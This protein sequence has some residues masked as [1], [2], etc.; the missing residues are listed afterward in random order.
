[1]KQPYNIK[2]NFPWQGMSEGEDYMWNIMSEKA[3]TS[4]YSKVPL[5]FRALNLRCNALNRVPIYIY[6]ARTEVEEYPFEE[7]FPLKDLLWLAEASVL[8][9]GS[10]YL[11]K[12]QNKYNIEKGLQWLNPTTMNVKLNEQNEKVFWQELNGRRYPDNGFWT[13]DELLYWAMFN[14]LNDLGGGV[15]ALSLASPNGD[16]QHY[17]TTFLNKFFKSGAMPVTMVMLPSGTQEPERERVENWFKK[18]VQGLKNAFRVLGVRGELK[19]EKMTPELKSFELEK[20]D[21]HSIDNIAWAFDIPKTLLT[22]DSSNKA[23]ADTEYRNF[24][25]NTIEPR[26]QWFETRINKWLSEYNYRI[27][28]APQEMAEMKEDENKKATAFKAYVDAGMSLQLAAAVTGVDIPE[29]FESFWDEETNKPQ[30]TVL[31]PGQQANDETQQEDEQQQDMQKWYRKS[32][33][34][35]RSGKNAQCEFVSAFIPEDRRLKVFESL[36]EI[37]NDVELKKLFDA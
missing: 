37:K 5:I 19:V 3:H 32:L 6:R 36:S 22:S 29:D 12:L 21:T 17:V 16:L 11:L 1:M 23:T 25:S 8:I 9:T 4:S 24:I 28:F 27:E 35:I 34:R 13:E 10:S 20:L 14:P 30:P 26:C 33:S 2:M 18:S 15:S 7:E 31:Q